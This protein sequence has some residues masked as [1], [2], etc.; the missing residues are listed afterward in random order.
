MAEINAEGLTSRIEIY[1]SEIVKI[2]EILNILEDKRQQRRSF[3]NFDHEIKERF[4]EIGLIVAVNWYSA[5]QEMPDGSVKEI[6]GVFIP[7]IVIKDRTEKKLFDHEQQRHEV[8]NNILELPNQEKG[9]LLK[10]TPEDFKKL[11]GP[12]EHHH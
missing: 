5:G 1:D 4:S 2:N 12:R 3:E 9:Q 6:E 11:F 8:V 10:A 7:E